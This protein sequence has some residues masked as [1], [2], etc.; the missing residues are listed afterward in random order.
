MDSAYAHPEALVDV[1]WIAAHLDDPAVRLV[2]VDVSPATY[3]RGHIP[4]AVM[5][6]A[7]TD[8]RG[9]AY[10]PVSGE[11]IARLFSR[12]GISP[13]TTVVFYGYGGVLGFW[14]MKLYGH[15][16][17]RLLN[18]SRDS[19]VQ[20]GHDWTTV[21]PAIEPSTYPP[22]RE[23]TDLVALRDTVADDI[24]KHANLLVDVRSRAEY[25]GENFWPSGAPYETGRAGRWATI[26][27]ASRV[28]QH[29]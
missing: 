7:Y 17:V 19:W 4:G 24:G 25:V 23:D 11:A 15:D 10:R 2:E 18:G 28:P 5:W 20:A 13:E 29:R 12:S 21:V 14:L 22:V 6:N 27:S 3:D 26:N 1:A 16:D 9:N 8:L